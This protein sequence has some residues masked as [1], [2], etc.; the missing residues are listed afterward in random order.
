MTAQEAA[1]A[2]HLPVSKVRGHINQGQLPLVRGRAGAYR[3]PR[4]A[5]ARFGEGYLVGA[6]P[7]P[8]LADAR[9]RV[10]RRP[11]PELGASTVFEARR[12]VPPQ[13][14]ACGLCEREE[15]LTT[16]LKGRNKRTYLRLCE[17]CSHALNT[18]ALVA[19]GRPQLL[20]LPQGLPSDNAALP[21]SAVSP[22]HLRECRPPLRKPE[23]PDRESLT[24]NEVAQ[25][26]GLSRPAPS[27]TPSRWAS[28]PGPSG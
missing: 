25:V 10:P 3:I 8:W 16:A 6:D 18:L 19:G 14:A 21:G 4:R 26:L 15:P 7:K 1:D 5:V 12:L 24:V 28:C 2:L 9:R 20:N 23:W 22:D 13:V 27:T 17:R 11:A